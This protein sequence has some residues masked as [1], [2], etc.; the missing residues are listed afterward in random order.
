MTKLRKHILQTFSKFNHKPL[1]LRIIIEELGLRRNRLKEFNQTIKQMLEEH[2]IHQN[3]EDL[4]EVIE[5]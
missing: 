5:I 4:F 3:D 1:P 2:V